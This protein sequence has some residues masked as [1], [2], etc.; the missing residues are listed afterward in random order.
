[1]ILSEPGTRIH[2]QL[3]VAQVSHG[4]SRDELEAPQIALVEAQRSKDEPQI[5]DVD[6]PC[7]CLDPL[8]PNSFNYP[9]SAPIDKQWTFHIIS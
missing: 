6:T 9:H 7:L 1:M 4:S 2:C 8:V 5:M 3:Q